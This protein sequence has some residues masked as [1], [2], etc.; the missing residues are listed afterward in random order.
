L[1]GDILS[2]TKAILF[3]GTPH[4]GADSAVWAAY[5]GNLARGLGFRTAEVTQ[6]L[7]RWSNPLVE[8]TTSFS[9]LAQKFFIST[10][11]QL[12]DTCGIKV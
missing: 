2:S 5:L 9:G 10:F 1:Y 11:F 3:F 6:E 12:W 7:Q 8:L 4:Q